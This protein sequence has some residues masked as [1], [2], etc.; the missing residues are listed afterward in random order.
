MPWK[1]PDVARAKQAEYRER[2]R[3]KIAR[4]ARERYAVNPHVRREGN[5]RSFIKA[6]YGITHEEKHAILAQQGGRCAICGTDDPP[7][8]SGWHVDHCHATNAVRGILCQH[9]NNMLGMAKDR[10][11]IFERAIAYLKGASNG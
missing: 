9:C 10:P 1:D 7:T 4:L 5:R 3:E 2:N 6:R 11:E 8:K